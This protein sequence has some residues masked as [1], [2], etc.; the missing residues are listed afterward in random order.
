M[1]LAFT[2]KLLCDLM[3]WY[4]T[5]GFVLSFYGVSLHILSPF[6]IILVSNLSG[7]LYEKKPMFR[8]FPFPLLLLSLYTMKSYTDLLLT[9]PPILYCVWLCHEARFS[10]DYEGSVGY[11]KTASLL[12][13]VISLLALLGSTASAAIVLRH[14]LIF[15]FSG[16]FMLRLLRHDQQSR[17]ELRLQIT[18]FILLILLSAAA[19]F[20]SSELFLTAVAKILNLVYQNVIGPLL[21]LISYLFLMFFMLIIK[22]FSFLKIG[23]SAQKQEIQMPNIS[24]MLNL[25]PNFKG[26]KSEFLMHLLTVLGIAVFLALAFFIFRRIAAGRSE[27]KSN[28]IGSNVVSL[29]PEAR[30]S[31][32]SSLAPRTP[33]ELVRLY[34]RRFLRN[35]EKK[36]IRFG[37]SATSEQIERLCQGAYETSLL[38]EMRVI[39]IAARYSPNIIAREDASRMKEVCSML[40]KANEQDKIK[41]H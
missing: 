32:L 10:P 17:K 24:E 40:M 1:D 15:L 19:L 33:R 30:P 7:I 27:E 18:D 25:D 8:Y 11:F 39:Y 38:S 34:Y 22:L 21:L 28:T 3:L 13:L 2:A 26:A 9:I 23:N 5:A 37:N 12:L 4:G 35:A 41:R 29:K 14:L 20:F 31:I 6:I 16:V 36:G